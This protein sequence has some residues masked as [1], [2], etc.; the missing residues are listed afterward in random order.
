MLKE[1][2]ED[3]SQEEKLIEKHPHWFVKGVPDRDINSFVYKKDKDI[4]DRDI[5]SFVYEKDKDK[6]D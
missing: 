3:K 6:D 5:N 1:Y 4:S 2:D